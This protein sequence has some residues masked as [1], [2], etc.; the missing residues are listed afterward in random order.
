MT[1]DQTKLQEIGRAFFEETDPTLFEKKFNFYYKA[2]YPIAYNSAVKILKDQE[3]A[4]HV[5]GLLFTQLWTSKLMNKFQFDNEKSHSGYIHFCATNKSKLELRRQ[6]NERIILESSMVTDDM[7]ETNYAEKVFYN[8][9]AVAVPEKKRINDHSDIYDDVELDCVVYHKDYGMGVVTGS[10]DDELAV[11]FDNPNH[12]KKK[13]IATGDGDNTPSG[14]TDIGVDK[15]YNAE[16]VTA[17]DE[18]T[19]DEK[20]VK[21]SK[22]NVSLC[23]K[24]GKSIYMK[25][26][27]KYT[28]DTISVHRTVT[29]NNS[30]SDFISFDDKPE[31]LFDKIMGS[32]ESN[33]DKIKDILLNYQD[34]GLLYDAIIEKINYTELAKKYNLDTPGA[35]KTR[36][37]RAKKRLCDMMQ[38]EQIIQ[39]LQNGSKYTGELSYYDERARLLYKANYVGGVLHGKFYAF[40]LNNC[41]TLRVDT[42]FDNGVLSKI[43]KKSHS[44]SYKEYDQDNKM[45][46]SGTFIGNKEHGVFQYWDNNIIKNRIDWHMGEAGIIYHFENGF[47][48][49]C[50]FTDDDTHPIPLMEF[51]IELYGRK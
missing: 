36:V 9:G 51:K 40:H 22:D 48:I 7:E 42:E 38:S 41:S 18:E 35:V 25:A 32:Y 8:N 46:I 20:I 5:A 37:F 4:G 29:I 16:I 11:I 17:L 50:K 44:A 3:T 23:I 26:V 49:D 19:G 13:K 27:D 15:N 45:I 33:Y 47:K 24:H 12:G 1:V 43:N 2:Y 34:Q 14:I 31:L 21:I 30:N 10:T 39:G 28:T 6:K